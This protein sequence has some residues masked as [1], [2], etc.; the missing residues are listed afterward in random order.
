MLVVAL[1][2]CGGARTTNPSSNPTPSQDTVPTATVG[3]TCRPIEP[4]DVDPSA[5]AT[6]GPTQGF[7]TSPVA[8]DAERLIL[9]GI[10]LLP[11]CSPAL[12]TTIAWWQTDAA[13]HY[14]PEDTAQPLQCFYYAATLETD[15]NARFEIHTIRPATNPGSGAELPAHIHMAIGTLEASGPDTGIQF[16]D[17]PL[18]QAFEG[19][20]PYDLLLELERRTDD[21]GDHW[22]GYA[23]IVAVPPG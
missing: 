2:A 15:A 22:F 6:L 17:D 23:Q 11:D 16:A 8:D 19:R 1:A 13:V 5:V 14:G 18:A 7:G 4:A 21:A 9:V 3:A 12:N 10:V 20:G